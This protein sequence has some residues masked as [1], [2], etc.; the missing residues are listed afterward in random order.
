MK[1]LWKEILDEITPYEPGRPIEEVKRELGL[2]KV[3]KLASNENPYGPSEK[4]M[5]AIIS[6]ARSAN[7]YPDGGCFY[8]RE[9]LSEKLSVP[10]EKIVFGNGS[11]E[12][13]ILAL[14]AFVH[15]GEEVIISDPT[16]LVYKIGSKI[17]GADIKTVP[18]KDFEYDLDGILEAITSKTKLIFIANPENPTGKYIP[19]ER[20]EA[21]LEKVPKDVVVF[22][23]EAYYEFATGGDYPETIE[24]TQREDKNII[25]SRTFSKA[26][27]L[28][29][30]RLGYII[31]RKD[32]AKAVNKVRE[33]FNIN[34]IAQAAAIA[35]LDDDE[36]LK[37]SVDLVKNEKEKLSEAF[38]GLDV[39]YVESK[40][41]FIL[42][43]TKR[44]SKEVFDHCLK[45]G[46]II[47]EMSAWSLEGFIRVNV[48]LPEENDEFIRVF[49]EAIK[50]VPK[51]G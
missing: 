19:K 20:L 18:V 3:I 25:V 22:M 40:T 32:L 21:F 14:R 24:L 8:L 47:R 43:D 34:S 10:G 26:Y 5:E 44:D 49:T 42:V 45:N 2:E 9:A 50:K 41:N 30:L 13:I 27:S 28:A 6:A 12:L 36:S 1:K 38:R 33:P 51:K 17:V 11:D 29:G 46:I 23:D 48:G 16:F 39:E 15:P 35:A 37:A 31:A 4:V 7:R